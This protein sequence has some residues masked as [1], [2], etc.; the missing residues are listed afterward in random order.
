MDLK[1]LVQKYGGTSL[2]MPEQRD[3]VIAKIKEALELNYKLVVVVSAMG[4][5]GAPYATDTLLKLAQDSGGILQKREQDLLLSCGEIIS[6][7]ILTSILGKNGIDAITLTG[8]QAGIITNDE[9]TDSRIISVKPERIKRELEKGKVVVVTGFQGKT[10]KDEITTLGRGG[11]DTSAAALG[12]ALE[13]ELVEIYTDVDGIKTADPR[14]VQDAKTLSAVTYNEICHL[15]HDGAKVIHP[16]AVEVAMQ[17][18][19]PLKIKS[20]FTKEPGTIISNKIST[21]ELGVEINNY[22]LITGITQIPNITQLKILTEKV[23]DKI[24]IEAKVFKA[25][26]LANISIDFINVHPDALIFTVKD[27]NVNKAVEILKN[28]DIY[29]EV[30]PDCAKISAVGAGMAGIPGVMAQI[31]EALTIEKIK[32]L[33]SADSH[34]TIWCLV[35]RK[36]METAVRALHKKFKLGEKI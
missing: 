20:T 8:T 17:H 32:I 7:V 2:A 13:A 4:R 6:G 26:A 12:V 19:L 10:S 14:I 11:S 28:M 29:P 16:R 27:D 34:T 1:I 3:F 25:L 35:A 23:K 15:A 22:G 31:V 36:D 30:Y 5:L 9:H 18:N 33:Q 24:D 21:K